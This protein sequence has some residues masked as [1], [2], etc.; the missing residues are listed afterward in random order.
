[1]DLKNKLTFKKINFT[2]ASLNKKKIVISCDNP[3]KLSIL[4]EVRKEIMKKIQTK[5]DNTN[6]IVFEFKLTQDLSK[7]NKT[8]LTIIQPS[9][10]EEVKQ[11]PSVNCRTENI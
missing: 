1:M 8:K 6:N 10:K 11:L 9:V 5:I 7:D 2:Y 4:V 3:V